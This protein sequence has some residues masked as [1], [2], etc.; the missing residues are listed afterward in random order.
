M[1]TTS[2]SN[3]VRESRVRDG[4]SGSSLG[5]SG[6]ELYTRFCAFSAALLK[7]SEAPKAF[8]TVWVFYA[9]RDVLEREPPQ[10]SPSKA[11]KMSPEQ[12]RALDVRIAAI[13]VRDGAQALWNTDQ[14]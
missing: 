6:G 1:Y 8:E 13:W 2:C 10:P 12:L 3:G 4:S 7:A 5:R 11:H 14:E 9:C